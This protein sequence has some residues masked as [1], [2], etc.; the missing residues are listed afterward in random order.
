[1]R[2][3]PRFLAAAVVA[4]VIAAGQVAVWPASAAV[5]PRA[6]AARPAAGTGPAGVVAA[7]AELV[8]AGTG[9]W[10]WGRRTLIEHPIASITKV[11]T[12]LV[13]IE[14]GNLNRKI[15]VSEAARQYGRTFDPGSAGLHPRDLLTARQLPDSP[16]R[17]VT[18]CCSRRSVAGTT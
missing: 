4:S 1:M 9:R 7:S 11:M 15:R 12:A 8:N 14:A 17:P 16:A 5:L 3:A 13:V 18:A 10:L 2:R 6:A